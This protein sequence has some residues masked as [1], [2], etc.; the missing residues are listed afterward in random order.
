MTIKQRK[1]PYGTVSGSLKKRPLRLL[2][3]NGPYGT[4]SGSLKKRPLRLLTVLTE[5]CRDHFKSVHQGIR[6]IRHTRKNR[7]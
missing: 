2:K 3:G 4:V 7:I 1:G 5:Q 6:L